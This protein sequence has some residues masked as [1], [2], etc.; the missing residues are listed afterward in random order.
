MNKRLKA[1]YYMCLILFLLELYGCT[2]V[3]TGI[4]FVGSHLEL[5]ENG[6]KSLKYFT[7]DSN[8]LMGVVALILV[9]AIRQVLK[10]RK[11]KLAVGYYVLFLVGAVGVTLTMLV[12]IFFL[13]PTSM[14]TGSPGNSLI[15]Q[16]R[17]GSTVS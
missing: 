2:W 7:T 13:A 1:A 14:E 9:I 4:H 10:G 6:L 12:T 5:S 17:T 11:D 3:F 8:V 15:S 16:S